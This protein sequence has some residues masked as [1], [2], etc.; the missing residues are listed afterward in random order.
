[1]DKTELVSHIV[2]LFRASGYKADSSVKVNHREIDVRAEELHGLVR[3]IILIECADYAGTVGVDKLQ[4]D[5]AKLR[6]AKEQ[7]GDRAVVMHVSTNGYTPDAAGYAADQGVP[8]YTIADLQTK[9][10]NFD[11]YLAAIA[12]D[13]AYETIIKEYQPNKVHFERTPDSAQPSIV[14]LREWLVSDS[15]WLTLLGDYGV[16]KSWTLKRL[17]YNL[18]EEYRSDPSRKPLPFFVPLQRF[19]KAFD[20]ENLILRTLQLYAVSGVFYSAF[21]YLMNHGRIVFLLDSFDEMAQHL[22]RDVIREN[23]KEMLVGI[24]ASSK[25]IMTSRPNYFEGRAERLLVVEREGN[26][27][28]HALDEAEHGARTAVSR[29]IKDRL[30][31]GQYA[32]IRDLTVEQRKKL[33]QIVLDKDSK[34]YATLL[35]LFNR[36]QNLENLSARAVI[37][38]L[39]T[40]VAATLAQEKE[41]LTIEGYPLLPADLA[42]LNEAKVFEIVIYNLLYRDQGIG[43][44]SN[45]QRLLF[46]RSFA[47]FIQQPG[48]DAFVEPDD[49]RHF[50]AQLFEVELRRSDTPQQLLENFYRTCRRHSGLTTESQFR[51]TSGQLDTPVDEG[52]NE[53]R[54]GFSHNSIRE[55]L[56]ADAV[57]N[58]L[59]TNEVP[60]QLRTVVMNGVIGDFFRGLAELDSDLVDKLRL[61]YEQSL[62]PSLREILFQVIYAFIRFDRTN[63][64]LL[65]T[66]PKLREIDLSGLDMS[67]LSLAEAEFTECLALDTDLRKSDLRK[68][69]FSGSV[70]EQTAFDGALLNEC[71]FTRTEVVSIYVF[72]DYDS[73][74]SAVLKDRPARQWLYSRGALVSPVDDLNP[75][76]GQPWY[77]AAREVTKTL[78]RRIGG[79]HQD[80][81]L[82]K[83]TKTQYR[84]FAKD[85]VDYL[86]TKR[87]LERVTKSATGPGFVVRVARQ[88][89]DAIRK[90][91]EAGEISPELQPFFDKHLKKKH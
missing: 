38:R 32:R 68:A 47:V 19:T 64:R 83:G 70:L 13:P 51:D 5:I 59:R 35:A 23:L 62:D 85:F 53:S 42:H 3:K 11:S 22:S 43:S 46:L 14:F 44:L 9:L 86:V 37:A 57:A 56:V 12:A 87:V 21:E 74:T 16:G 76:L 24:G 49:L 58:F 75:L 1:M 10:I 78:Q 54:V 61:G 66:P 69:I 89:R 7:L 48:R 71:D 40:T 90:F 63:A 73:R 45:A 60:P 52:D 72:D 18:A 33:F 25:A 29:L 4:A 36:F 8:A 91:S 81:S 15:R 30:A 20:F 65:G 6:A 84:T 17:L 34:A 55:F 41:I 80:V 88:H 82:A 39:L 26:V 79:T 27:Q 28:W 77:E 67:G 50:V 2:E 31:T